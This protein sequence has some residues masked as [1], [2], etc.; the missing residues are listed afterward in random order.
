MIDLNLGRLGFADCGLYSTTLAYAARDVVTYLGSTYRC[1]LATTAGQDPA[2]FPTHW[3]LMARGTAGVYTNKGDLLTSD[4]ADVLRLPIGSAGHVLGV[5]DGIPTWTPPVSRQGTMAA[6]LAYN[7]NGTSVSFG[8]LPVIM[9]DGAIKM[10]GGSSNLCA[11][12][13]TNNHVINPQPVAFDPLN[14]PAFP[15]VQVA[16]CFT[17]NYALDSAGRVYAWGYN[18]YGQLGQGDTTNRAVAT[19]ITWFA[20]QN[21]PIAEII[22]P[23]E[24]GNSVAAGC[25]FF[26]STDGRVF[27]CGYNVCGQ[28]G[29]G[30]LT[31]SSLPVR[32]GTIASIA[33][34]FASA[35]DYTSVFAIDSAGKLYAWGRNGHGQ[36]GLGDVVDRSTPTQV[37]NIVNAKKVCATAG[38][39]GTV[40]TG[41]TAVLCTD[42]SLY[43]TGCNAHGALGLGDI[44]QR[45]VFS[46][47]NTST[48]TPADME[49]F[50]GY[51]DS[52]WVIDTVGKLWACGNNA[53]GQLGLG[54]LISRTT[55][56]QVGGGQPFDG[57]VARL[58]AG[59]N[60]NSSGQSVFAVLQDTTGKL[61]ATGYNLSGQLAVG[62][63]TS[64]TSF[65]RVTGPRATE[66]MGI[67]DYT[68]GGYGTLGRL[69]VLTSDG[70]VWGAGDNTSFSLGTQNTVARNEYRLSDV[71]F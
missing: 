3:V 56:T 66:H 64:R 55:L 53:Y 54:D 21:I 43:V 45:N 68:M 35:Q 10:W 62:D 33:K 60:Q 37:P 12:D 11:G 20:Q 39:Q 6:A 41:D 46:K 67:V 19:Q 22:V 8:G 38:V 61:W 65:S 32:C 40:Y 51:C 16:T 47:L 58:K 50:G 30:T 36:L 7:P 25:V 2:G 1:T 48:F 59:G 28:L 52:L 4:G 42:G 34:V 9:T 29:N 63:V 13:A 31:N 44:I 5:K 14:S 23:R 57:K 24:G 17:S 49:L 70:R 69:W 26:R 15:M 18:A 71:I 27:G